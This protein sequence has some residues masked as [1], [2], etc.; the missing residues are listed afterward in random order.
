MRPCLSK[1]FLFLVNICVGLEIPFLVLGKKISWWCSSQVDLFRRSCRSVG[2]VHNFGCRGGRRQVLQQ[3]RVACPRP[4]RRRARGVRQQWIPSSS[5]RRAASKSWQVIC[6]AVV[7]DAS[8]KGTRPRTPR[9]SSPLV[10]VEGHV[11]GGVVPL[12]HAAVDR[13][14]LVRAALHQ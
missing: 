14:E 3:D 9:G 7:A 4:R 12:V 5:H 11:V 8:H 13:V 6:L 2:T 1:G 10:V